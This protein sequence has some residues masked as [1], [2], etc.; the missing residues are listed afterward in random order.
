MGRLLNILRYIMANIC[1]DRKGEDKKLHAFI[2]FIIAVILGAIVA[3]FGLNPW[4]AATIVFVLAFSVGIWKEVKDSKTKGN[5]FCV[6]DL[7]ADFI[8][9]LAGSIIA[10]LAAYFIR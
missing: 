3:H 1:T 7:S 10:W 6:W 2:E 4:L 5:H 9:C 8:G